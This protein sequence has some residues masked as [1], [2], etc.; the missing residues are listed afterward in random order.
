MNFP[1]RFKSKIRTFWG[2][3]EELSK[4]KNMVV[5]ESFTEKYGDTF[6]VLIKTG[7]VNHI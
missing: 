2:E 1:K 4:A 3:F 7:W 5:V 6:K